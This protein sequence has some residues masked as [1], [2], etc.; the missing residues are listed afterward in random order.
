MDVAA[1]YD[2]AK[3]P[4]RANDVRPQRHATSSISP[5]A[6]CLRVL[7]SLLVTSFHRDPVD[8]EDL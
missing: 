6:M 3:K 1:R 4:R 5:G 2:C 8:P 7:T